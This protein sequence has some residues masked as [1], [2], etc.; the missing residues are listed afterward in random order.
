MVSTVNVIKGKIA[1]ISGGIGGIGYQFAKVLLKSDIKGVVLLDVD[2][3]KAPKAVNDLR[4]YGNGNVEFVHADCKSMYHVECGLQKAVEVFGKL[5]YVINNA[6]IIDENEMD[7]MVNI[8]YMSTVYSTI[9]SLYKILP[10]S[11]TENEG[12]IINNA[13]IFGIDPLPPS[14]IYSALKH[15]VVGVSR[16]FGSPYYYNRSKIKVLSLCPGLT[17]T[18]LSSPAKIDH[19]WEEIR[20]LPRQ[21]AIFPARCLLKMLTQGENGSVWIAENQK[22]YQ[23]PF[24]N[25]FEFYS[26]SVK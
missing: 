4:A 13:C 15:A 23:M 26:E 5:D 12:V 16:S 9:L 6:A 20:K 18:Q 25:R 3:E 14:P 22:C 24:Q 1:C 8:N 19:G 17:E 10:D 7:I 21:G 11:L 2:A